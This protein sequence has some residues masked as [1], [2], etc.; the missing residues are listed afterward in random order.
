M[1]KSEV[2]ISVKKARES[3]KE[4]KFK[5]TF[6]LFV[7]LKNIN[8]EKA[9]NKLNLT[10]TLPNGPGKEPKICALVDKELQVKAKE[11]CY[12][13]ILKEDFG[14]YASN[15]RITRKLA[16]ECDF[17]IAQGNIMADIA[18]AFGKFLGARGKMPDPK[19]GAV[20][21]PNGEVKPV[22]EKFKKLSIIKTKNTPTI[23]IRIGSEQMKDEEVAENIIAVYSAIE[24]AL[25]QRH[26]QVRAV[27]VKLTM[28]PTVRING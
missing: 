26:D 6:D 11:V 20:I 10:V 7:A 12:K 15:S 24:A 28:G 5:Q 17:F 27:Y 22:V 25:P 3:G 2:I 21:P 9:D 1:E 14:K 16:N 19:I 4:R 13:V 8:L 18:T 23:N